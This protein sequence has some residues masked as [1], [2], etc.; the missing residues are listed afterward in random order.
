MLSYR[1]L[2]LAALADVK[3]LSEHGN[4]QDTKHT[5]KQVEHR[6]EEVKYPLLFFNSG[7]SS[8]QS[9]SWQ[10]EDGEHLLEVFFSMQFCNV[11]CD[12]LLH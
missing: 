1:V 8:T 11:T 5:Y 12:P 3:T 9:R 7:C 2:V 4:P 10:C 6:A